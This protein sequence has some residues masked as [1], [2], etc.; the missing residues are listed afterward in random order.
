MVDIGIEKHFGGSRDNIYSGYDRVE[1]AT[2]NAVGA[3]PHA[4]GAILHAVGATPHRDG[5]TLKRALVGQGSG[6][7]AVG[8]QSMV[9]I[10]IEKQRQYLLRV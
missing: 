2:L 3:K 9:D 7:A 1:S 4:D 8:Q 5:S 10:G 6:G